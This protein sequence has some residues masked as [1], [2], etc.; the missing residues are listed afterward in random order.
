M[1]IGSHGRRSHGLAA[2]IASRVMPHGPLRIP[3]VVLAIVAGSCTQTVATTTTSASVAPTA[4]TTTTAPTTTSPVKPPIPD[5]VTLGIGDPVF[6][7][8]GNPATTFSTTR[9]T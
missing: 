4:T 8:L 9:S 6:A 7:D 1:Q 2:P 5:A 3:V